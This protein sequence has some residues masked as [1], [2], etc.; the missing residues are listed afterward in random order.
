MGTLAEFVQ[1]LP[2]EKKSLLVETFFRIWSIN[3]FGTMT[4]KDTE[5]LLFRCLADLLGDLAPKT[6][7]GWAH[8]LRV[9]PQK[10]KA[11]RLE[12]HLRFGHLFESL[13]K[14]VPVK[15]FSRLHG[16]HLQFQS[17][18][19]EEF[20]NEARVSF[21]LED[22]VAQME[23]EN[24]LKEVGTYLDFHRN[25]EVVRLR[26]VDFLKVVQRHAAVKESGI[27]DSLLKAKLA[28]KKQFGSLRARLKAKEYASK[29][30]SQKL[31]T[32]VELLGDTFAA[33]PAA[34][35]RHLRLIFKAQKEK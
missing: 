29:S 26:F 31:L 19:A 8:L 33:K 2:Q 25:R 20:L 16:I 1:K 27:I 30:E 32:F 6:N 22:P 35:V 18:T 11:F 12:S 3:G 23:L 10:V 34:L 5:L 7:Y 14:E 28:D 15:Y 21:V 17:D 4:K 9:T 24:E 13:K